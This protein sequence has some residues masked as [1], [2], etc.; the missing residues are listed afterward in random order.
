MMTA[1]CRHPE[2][3]KTIVS[4]ASWLR[5][6]KNNSAIKNKP[7]VSERLPVRRRRKNSSMPK[8]Y[9]RRFSELIIAL[10]LLGP[11][12]CAAAD[13]ALAYGKI[14][15]SPGGTGKT[16][17]GREIAQVMSWHGAAWLERAERG[18]EERPDLLLPLLPIRPGMV[19]ADIGAGSG[20]Y[21]RRIA[22]RL[23]PGG[24]VVA[25]DVQPEMITLLKKQIAESKI[26]NID[27]V[28]ATE[29][30]CKLPAESIDLALFVDVYHELLYPIETMGCIRRALK[31][32]GQ[33]ALVEFRAEDASVPIKPQ[34]KM[35]EAQ[36]KKEAALLGLQWVA[37]I[38]SLPWQHLVLLK[39]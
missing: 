15:T 32:G 30:D 17:A 29:T 5:N 38:S 26:S 24:R 2:R 16:F 25:V 8:R 20:Y 36:I 4:S 6:A 21:S 39:K 18:T 12:L 28:L 13:S 33:I 10:A 14:A 35:S 27:T 11:T 3:V 22:P 19:V 23:A 37:T 31:N 34:H 1:C 7:G 9:I